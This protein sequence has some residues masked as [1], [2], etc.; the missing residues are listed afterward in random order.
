[1]TTSNGFTAL[2]IATQQNSI[3]A[4]AELAN[5]EAKR[6]DLTGTTALMMAAK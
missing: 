5:K 2:M 4:I 3:D 6:K 1:M